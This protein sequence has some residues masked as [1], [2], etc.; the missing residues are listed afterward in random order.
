MID[1]LIPKIDYKIEYQDVVR[2]NT[3][4]A[5]K[6]MYVYDKG[7][8]TEHIKWCRRNLGERGDGWDFA[9]GYKNITIIIWSSRLQT[10]YEMWQT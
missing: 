5:G 7:N 3:D 6:K 1:R 4:T 10:M 8:N 2:K 9:G